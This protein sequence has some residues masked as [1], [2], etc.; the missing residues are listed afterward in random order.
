MVEID[1]GKIPRRPPSPGKFTRSGAE[2]DVLTG[3]CSTSFPVAAVLGQRREECQHDGAA[4]GIWQR[5]WR[6][7]S[8]DITTLGRSV[9]SGVV[10]ARGLVG[11]LPGGLWP[12][13]MRWPAARNSGFGGGIAAG[14][15]GGA[16]PGRHRWR[17]RLSSAC[18]A[19]AHRARRVQSAARR[20][21]ALHF[22]CRAPVH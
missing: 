2:R 3:C 9:L 1:Q 5:P 19:G 15:G 13:R 12:V 8:P 22:V 18:R 20:H 14:L 16:A 21:P 10:G 11:V 6:S 17:H 4:S 7:G